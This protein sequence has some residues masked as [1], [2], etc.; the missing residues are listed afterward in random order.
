MNVKRL[1]LPT[2]VTL[3]LIAGVAT[4][5]LG[6]ASRPEPA[7]AGDS[8]HVLSNVSVT[9][10]YVDASGTS[11]KGS[12]GVDFTVTW[13][14]DLNPGTTSCFARVFDATG[15]QIGQQYFSMTS[16][17]NVPT[18]FDPIQVK[19]TD[20]PSSAEAYCGP[21]DPAQ[22]EARYEI[23]NLHVEGGDLFAD[24]RWAGGTDPVEQYCEA[25]FGSAGGDTKVIPFTLMAD[26]GDQQILSLGASTEGMT[27]ESASCEPFAGQSDLTDRINELKKDNAS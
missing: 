16:N 20:S 9:Y 4:I 15:S 26:E 2:A 5:S 21:A 12:A 25:T 13:S 11:L 27:P 22:V 18:S 17:Q 24:V 23:S 19:V 6:E 3:G 8:S 7:E 10:P 1:V 14:T